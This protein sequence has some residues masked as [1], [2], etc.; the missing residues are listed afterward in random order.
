MRL[1]PL[2]AGL[3]AVAFA[4]ACASNEPNP[5]A[6]PGNVG[7]QDT[8]ATAPSDAIPTAPPT[9][10]APAPQE[11]TCEYGGKTR[12]VGESFPSTDGCNTCGCTESGNVACTEK[13]CAPAPA[14]A[15]DPAKE[16][17]REY[18]MRS[19]DQCK[20]ALFRCETGKKPFFNACGCGCE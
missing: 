9:T 5:P 8:T 17:N 16:P 19:P 7:P 18:K 14:A 4:A 1:P 6:P 2:F 13:A 12:A 15:C 20:A 11:K 3:L 10:T